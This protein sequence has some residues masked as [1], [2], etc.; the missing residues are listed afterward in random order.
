V[1]EYSQG[2]GAWAAIAASNYIVL[3]DGVNAY[4]SLV[5]LPVLTGA[6]RD[7]VNG[8]TAYWIRYRLTVVGNNPTISAYSNMAFDMAFLKPVGGDYAALL[9]AYLYSY[10]FYYSAAPSPSR[11]MFALHSSSRIPDSLLYD[12]IYPASVPYQAARSK[13]IYTPKY[14][15]VGTV[16]YFLLPSL[17]GGGGRAY[18]QVISPDSCAPRIECVYTAV[19]ARP[20]DNAVYFEPLDLAGRFRVLVGAKATGVG[21]AS[22]WELSLRDRASSGVLLLTE[23]V[24]VKIKD[25]V[26]ILDFGEINWPPEISTGQ[27]GRGYIQNYIDVD[28]AYGGDGV[29]ANTLYIYWVR[30]IPVDEFFADIYTHDNTTLYTLDSAFVNNVLSTIVLDSAI[31]KKEPIIAMFADKASTTDGDKETH[32]GPAMI[33]SASG[34]MQYSLENYVAMTGLAMKYDVTTGA[35]YHSPSLAAWVDYAFVSRYMGIRGDDD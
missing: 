17:G 1:V 32:S 7:A 8:R 28:I 10:N 2:A 11:L 20:R 34:K 29:N 33:A 23:F 26:E 21:A 25:Q 24:S 13:F 4:L 22:L 12:E 6:A 9:K 14:I 5:G 18:T 30:M 15:D 35:W 3:N 16:D 19:A 31:T 27:T